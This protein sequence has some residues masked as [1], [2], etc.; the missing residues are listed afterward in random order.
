MRTIAKSEGLRSMDHSQLAQQNGTVRWAGMFVLEWKWA[1]L[2]DR[3]LPSTTKFVLLVLQSHM[4]NDGT[5]ATSSEATLAWEANLSERCVRDHLK[6]AVN[7]GWITRKLWRSK[8]MNW[9]GYAY[10]AVIPKGH[11]APERR[12]GAN[13]EGQELRSGPSSGGQEP[14]AIGAELSGSLVGKDVPTNSTV[15]STKNSSDDKKIQ[16]LKRARTPAQEECMRKAA[17][18]RSASATRLPQKRFA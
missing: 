3:G 13:G 11:K 10:T 6:I 1:V 16:P 14:S 15:N 7:L 17:E 9:A 12:S 8:G 4:H 18:M 2:R 5:G